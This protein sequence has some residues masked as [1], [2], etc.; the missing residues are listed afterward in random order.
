MRDIDLKL[1]E[2][3]DRQDI[4]QLFARYCRAVDRMD[5]ELFRTLFC[6]GGGYETAAGSFN[7]GDTMDLAEQVIYGTVDKLTAK[8]QHFISNFL[9]EFDAPT[10][11]HSEVYFVAHHRMH[12]TRES[13]DGILGQASMQALGG[14]YTRDYDA[15]VGGRY[16]DLLEKHDGVWKIRSRRI[17]TDWTAAGPASEFSHCADSLSASVGL[18]GARGQKDPSYTRAF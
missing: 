15:I 12:A 5:I 11:A 6:S 14:D 17:V 2:V 4:A 10:R 13:L 7:A 1:R 16:I 3:I 18:F 9:I 8:T